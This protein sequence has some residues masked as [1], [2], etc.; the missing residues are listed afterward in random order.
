M[1][2][3]LRS[4]PEAQEQPAGGA[5]EDQPAHRFNGE[6]HERK[7]SQ[8]HERAGRVTKPCDDQID[9]AL[10]RNRLTSL[11]RYVQQL[12]T[13]SVQARP[14][15]SIDQLGQDPEPEAGCHHCRDHTRQQH[16]GKKQQGDGDT[17]PLD[18]PARGRQLNCSR[19]AEHEPQDDSKQASDL[20]RR[21][22]VSLLQE[23][24][25]LQ[26]D[27]CRG[28]PDDQ[29]QPGQRHDVA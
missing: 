26:I 21:T 17:E 28:S 22:R 11:D 12:H 10:C 15:A 7:G 3:V 16:Q 20:L 19:Q 27:D 8:Q 6:A 1:L 23:S 14:E 2:H 13:N 25:E 24:F 5:Q 4:Q 18:D 29:D 9:N